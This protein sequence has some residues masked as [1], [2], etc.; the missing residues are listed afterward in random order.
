MT[1]ADW[2]LIVQILQRSFFRAKADLCFEL[3]R[4]RQTGRLLAVR[5]EKG[6][7]TGAVRRKRRADQGL[8]VV[9]PELFE[10]SPAWLTILAQEEWDEHECIWSLADTLPAE[11]GS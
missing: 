9:T 7:I 8:P 10:D 4:H 5:W 11:R 3:W 1:T 6:A 2:E